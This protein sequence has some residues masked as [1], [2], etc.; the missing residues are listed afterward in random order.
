MLLCSLAAVPCAQAVTVTL[1]AVASFSLQTS[2]GSS[3]PDG[4]IVQLILSEDAVA[5]GFPD[6]GNGILRMD[7]TLNDDFIAAE[8][9]VSGGSGKFDAF[10][11]NYDDNVSDPYYAY[12]R[13]FD[14]LS[15]PLAVTAIDWNSSPGGALPQLSYDGFNT[16]TRDFVPANIQASQND[17]FA[18]IPEPGTLSLLAL[19]G[20]ALFTIRYRM[21]RKSRRG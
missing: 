11:V 10:S 8:T 20:A 18:V 5:D 1:T 12:I 4:S 13:F 17:N 2:G 6:S 7:Q 19:F 9:T 15:Y 3:L 16:D 14:A 21:Y